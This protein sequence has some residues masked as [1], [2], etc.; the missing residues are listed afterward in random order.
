VSGDV[1]TSRVAD[2][3]S[4]VEE[5]F[6]SST[7]A[8]N[9]SYNQ[10]PLSAIGHLQPISL[11]S[12][13]QSALSTEAIGKLASNIIATANHISVPYTQSAPSATNQLPQHYSQSPTVFVSAANQL[14]A[15]YILSATGSTV[16]ANLPSGHH[17][18]SASSSMAIANQM[19][20]H[21][22]QSPTASVSA[23][24]HLPAH[25]S[26]SASTVPSSANYRSAHYSQFLASVR[27][28]TPLV[29][30]LNASIASVANSV[31]TIGVDVNGQI[32]NG[33]HE[34]VP[35][36]PAAVT[37]NQSDVN[38]GQLFVGDVRLHSP[39]SQQYQQSHDGARQGGLGYQQQQGI[40][41]YYRIICRHITKQTRNK[42]HSL[43][44][45]QK[46]EFQEDRK[47]KN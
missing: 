31:T 1:S 32:P 9:S 10:S 30:D 43:T 20:A 19:S 29:A 14:M 46:P 8:A 3:S 6:L 15:P 36:G 26:Q 44:Q 47:Q 45:M 35:N 18:Q 11:P 22:S 41:L 2:T 28:F 25:Y 5:S 4:L 24:S 34:S 42:Q 39:L 12:A 16:A 23:S 17:S 40:L 21:C 27:D 38:D 7:V 13:D 37:N 33:G